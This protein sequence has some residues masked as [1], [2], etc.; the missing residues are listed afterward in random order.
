MSCNRGRSTG[1]RVAVG[2]AMCVLTVG[3]PLPALA[4]PGAPFA[5]AL[6]PPPTVSADRPDARGFGGADPLV[7]CQGGGDVG[8]TLDELVGALNR[9]DGIK[10][11]TSALENSLGI[12]R[13]R[14]NYRPRPPRRVFNG[15]SPQLQQEIMRNQAVA[16]DPVPGDPEPAPAPRKPRQPRPKRSPAKVTQPD[17]PNEPVAAVTLERDLVE[18]PALDGQ[19]ER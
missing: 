10:Q 11:R 9:L 16:A 2:L 19:R 3:G 6:A 15:I 17:G 18:E 5:D 14:P 4:A 13:P 7:I 12:Q 8:V 1:A